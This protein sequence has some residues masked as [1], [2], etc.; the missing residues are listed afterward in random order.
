MHIVPNEA[1]SDRM[2][3]SMGNGGHQVAE[4]AWI[5]LPIIAV[6]AVVGIVVAK[7]HRKG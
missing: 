1:A 5:A 4:L 7:S 6:F 3:S 2:G